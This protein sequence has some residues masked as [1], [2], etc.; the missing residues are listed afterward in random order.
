[1]KVCLE[2]GCPVLSDKSR[3]PTH[4]R[5]RERA[6]GSS[7]ARGYGV[8]HRDLRATYQQRMDQGEAFIC[9]RGGEPIDPSN[10]TLGHCDDDRTTYHGPECPPC[11]YATAGRDRCPHVSHM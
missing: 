5:V 3:C 9:W 1:M 10:W 6:R 7:T 8:D 4:R 2:P 11:D